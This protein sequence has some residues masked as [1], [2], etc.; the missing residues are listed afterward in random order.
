MAINQQNPDQEDSN[1][2]SR[3]D[4]TPAELKDAAPPAAHPQHV[5][6][7]VAIEADGSEDPGACIEYMVE[8]Q[9][10]SG[11][12]LQPTS[13]TTTTADKPEAILPIVPVSSKASA[14]PGK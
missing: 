3:Q 4:C 1:L 7:Q 6:H 8:S 11:S 9:A 12:S 5:L 10:E 14:T 13:N 2:S